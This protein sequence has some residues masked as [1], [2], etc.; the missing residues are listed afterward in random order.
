[1]VLQGAIVVNAHAPLARCATARVA[2]PLSQPVTG[3]TGADSECTQR[4]RCSVPLPRT[5]SAYIAIAAAR[6]EKPLCRTGKSS[7]E[8]D[9]MKPGARLPSGDPAFSFR[10]TQLAHKCAPA[11][12]RCETSSESAN[13]QET[14]EYTPRPS[15]V[16][17][18]C[19]VG[20]HSTLTVHCAY[21]RLGRPQGSQ[22]P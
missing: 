13:S 2:T 16:V 8:A 18:N 15:T 1:M 20:L 9:V 12:G 4:A 19:A 5:Q 21:W 14:Y 11:S 22:H 3:L 6:D 7:T 17:P 10:E